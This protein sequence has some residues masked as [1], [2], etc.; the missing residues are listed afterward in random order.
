M[1]NLQNPVK[2]VVNGKEIF[3]KNVKADKNFLLE[4]FKKSFDRKALWVA[5]IK[6]IVL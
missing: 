6:A 1:T 4:N 5:S 3:N 2:V